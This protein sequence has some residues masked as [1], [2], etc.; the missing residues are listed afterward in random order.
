MS[1]DEHLTPAYR[2][3][4][5]SPSITR[6][7]FRWVNPNP[8]FRG[9]GGKK[10]GETVRGDRLNHVYAMLYAA[11]AQAKGWETTVSWVKPRSRERVTVPPFRSA[12]HAL[13]WIRDLGDDRFMGG[14]AK[15]VLA[16]TETYLTEHGT[17]VGAGH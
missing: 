3:A 17:D 4:M 15:R 9:T 16:H 14:E 13:A 7:V 1:R 6:G 8:R 5:R 11:S 2:K 10:A 12:E